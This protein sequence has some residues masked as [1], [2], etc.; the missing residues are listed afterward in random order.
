MKYLETAKQ[1]IKN[2]FE[3]LGHK[4]NEVHSSECSVVN[5]LEY[6]R[7]TCKS[8]GYQVFVN[9]QDNK[10]TVVRIDDENGIIAFKKIPYGPEYKVC[11]RL[12]VME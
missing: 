11:P 10:P 6:Y 12:A 5:D 7:T 4:P 2:V 8:C 1:V 3:S 9:I